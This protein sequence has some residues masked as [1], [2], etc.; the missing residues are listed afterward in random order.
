MFLSFI[1][2]NISSPTRLASVG[3]RLAALA[4]AVSF[5]ISTISA[6]LPRTAIRWSSA[7]RVQPPLLALD[8]SLHLLA[9]RRPHSGSSSGCA[10]VTYLTA[11]YSLLGLNRTP[12]RV[13]KGSQ[14]PP[15][16]LKAF[17]TLHEIHVHA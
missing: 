10:D 11:V 1:I 3:R 2:A 12:S 5:K 6:K 9:A 8:G 7:S 14:G 13:Y 17:L 4:S 15:V 16:L